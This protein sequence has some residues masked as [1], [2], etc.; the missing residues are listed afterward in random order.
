MTGHAKDHYSRE[1]FTS[2]NMDVDWESSYAYADSITDAGLFNMVGHPV[3]VC[4]D[5]KLHE[6]ALLK[7]WE[8]IG[9]PKS[10]Q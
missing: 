5:D 1:F 7:N 10:A 8:V 6:L 9:K 3:A 2:N 4:P